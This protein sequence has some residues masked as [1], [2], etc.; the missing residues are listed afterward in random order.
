[1]VDDVHVERHRDQYADRTHETWLMSRLTP[2]LERAL[3]GRLV[4][5]QGLIVDIGCGVGN[6]LGHLASPD[7]LLLGVDLSHAALRLATRTHPAVFFAQADA[8]RLPI[9]TGAVSMLL[10]RGCFHYLTAAD[11]S[12]YVRE[13][14]RV[15]APRSRLLLR[16]CLPHESMPQDINE[17]YLRQLFDGW[18]IELMQRDRLRVDDGHLNGITALLQSPIH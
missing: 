10:D 3:A 9:A 5:T 4:P 14:A 7:R 13:A 17:Q 6:E 1:M 2:E 16:A 18:S 12:A 11:R 8:C 15:L